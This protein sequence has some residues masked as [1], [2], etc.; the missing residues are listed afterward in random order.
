VPF[1][2]AGAGVA[3]FGLGWEAVGPRNQAGAQVRQRARCMERVLQLCFS[4][5]MKVQEV[6][7]AVFLA[8][9]EPG[10]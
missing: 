10:L 5:A 3:P 1:H 2:R 4:V 7:L 8:E 6:V 9:A